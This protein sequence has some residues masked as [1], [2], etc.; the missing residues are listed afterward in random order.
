[1]MLP[2]DIALISDPVF[3]KWVEIYAKDEDRFFKDF[4]KAFAKLLELGVPFA[5]GKAWWKFW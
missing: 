3:K 5:S 1:M 2:S 4:A